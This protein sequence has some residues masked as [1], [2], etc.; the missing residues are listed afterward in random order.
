MYFISYRTCISVSPVFYT[1]IYG[2]ALPDGV[3]RGVSDSES[4][5]SVYPDRLLGAITAGS[6]C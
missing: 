3:A 1:H 6:V 4:L 5:L 2:V